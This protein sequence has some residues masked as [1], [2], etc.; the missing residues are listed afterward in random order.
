MPMVSISGQRN[1]GVL[2]RI[3]DTKSVVMKSFAVKDTKA[4]FIFKII[5]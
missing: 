5:L 1:E 4:D 3:L 2:R